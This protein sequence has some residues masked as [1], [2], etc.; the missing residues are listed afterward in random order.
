MPPVSAN[1][2][3]Q[4]LLTEIDNFYFTKE[5]EGFEVLNYKD[6]KTAKEASRTVEA[7]T[8]HGLFCDLM[9]KCSN[10]GIMG[11]KMPLS[12]NLYVNRMEKALDD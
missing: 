12:I 6:V 10:Y 11:E 7:S 4:R 9:M 5:L 2:K 8:A 3:F 1:P